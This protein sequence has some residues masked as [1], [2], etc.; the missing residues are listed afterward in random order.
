MSQNVK[1]KKISFSSELERL[2]ILGNNWNIDIDD[3]FPK[4]EIYFTIEGAVGE[5]LVET[6]R[7]LV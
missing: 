1:T 7:K 2:V 3:F 6:S 5:K 4:S